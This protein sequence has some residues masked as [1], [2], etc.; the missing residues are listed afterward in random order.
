MSMFI[1]STDQSAMSLLF[2][3][4]FT[5]RAVVRLVNIVNCLAYDKV[6][7]DKW[8]VGWHDPIG[9]LLDDSVSPDKKI[10]ETSKYNKSLKVP[11][12]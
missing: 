10:Q 11:K 1:F 8:K 3:T 2:K 4:V 12:G 9:I 6:V 7:K 5:P